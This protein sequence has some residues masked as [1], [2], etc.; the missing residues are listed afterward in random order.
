MPKRAKLSNSHTR[1]Q[2][3]V[4]VVISA[5]FCGSLGCTDSA[6][7]KKSDSKYQV[8]DESDSA[9]QS[10]TPQDPDKPWRTDETGVNAITRMLRYAQ[11]LRTR[12]P[13]ASPEQRLED[14]QSLVEI[15]KDLEKLELNSDQKM[16]ALQMKSQSLLALLANGDQSAR[17]QLI[18]VVETYH[19]DPDP[20]YSRTAAFLDLSIAMN[21]YFSDETADATRLTEKFVDIAK[22]YPEDDSVAQRLTMLA[23]QM[24][25]QGRRNHAVN[26]MRGLQDVYANS[27]SSEL[28]SYSQR[29]EDRITLTEALYDLVVSEMMQNGNTEK[30]QKTLGELALH[31]GG[32][33]ELYRETIAGA[34]LLEQFGHYDEAKAI[35]EQL[36]KTYENS[37]D[38]VIKQQV[39]RD[40]EKGNRRLALIGNPL[41]LKG[42]LQD[43]SLFLPNSLSG[44]T[45]AVLFWSAKFPMSVRAMQPLMLFYER[46]KKR[47][48]E[49]VTVNI[50]EDAAEAMSIFEDQPPAWTSLFRND[51]SYDEML[52]QLGIQMVPYMMLVDK[53]GHVVKVHV[54]L[55]DLEPSLIE[56]VGLEEE[57]PS[58]IIYPDLDKQRDKGP[59]K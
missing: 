4:C 9:T 30:F 49:V 52:D 54:P 59:D 24:L 35:N 16:A 55:R 45:L 13:N 19:D 53:E 2:A 22:K 15:A 25:A 26:I 58:H 8:A 57:L 43:G 42:Q 50:D 32:G 41:K 51:E 46:F 34:R 20:D 36:L 39:T 1:I 29:L 11:M 10:S 38:P 56:L 31:E 5:C 14:F 21:D 6:A 48:F 3:M 37:E 7:T 23:S 18:E 40:V 28:A 17:P 47:G 12:Y 27:E 33:R 44:K